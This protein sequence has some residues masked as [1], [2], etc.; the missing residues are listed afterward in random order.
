MKLDEI[1]PKIKAMRQDKKLTQ[2][3]LADIAGISRVTLGKLERANLGSISLKTIDLILD[4][5]GYE[6]AFKQRNSFGL[7]TLDEMKQW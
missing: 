4:A 3:Q 6:L 2:K 7:P 1:G 5:L